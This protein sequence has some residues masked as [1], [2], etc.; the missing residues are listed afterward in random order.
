MTLTGTPLLVTLI[1]LAVLMPGIVIAAWPRLRGAAWLVLTQRVGLVLVAQLSTLLLAGVALNDYG[2]FFSSWSQAAGAFFANTPHNSLGNQPLGDLNSYG[3]PPNIVATNSTVLKVAP[4]DALP[5]GLKPTNW[6]P[7]SQYATRGAVATWTLDGPTSQL[8]NTVA[9]YLPPAYFQGYRS[10]PL[11]EAITGYPATYHAWIDKLTLPTQ[12]LDG[13]RARLMGQLVVVMTPAGVP[14]PL[15]SECTDAPGGPFAYTYFAKD[16]PQETARALG[17]RVT[18]MGALGFSTGGYCAIKLAMLDPSSFRAAAGMSGYFAAEP[19]RFS[20]PIFGGSAQVRHLNDL[21]WR[22]RH[23]PAPRTSVLV[24]TGTE[25]I[26][27]DGWVTNNK[28]LDAV[29]PP[30]HADRFIV[31]VD[32][33][34]S[35]RTWVQEVSPAL[36]WISRMLGAV[37]S[38]GSIGSALFSRQGLHRH[39]AH[40][41]R[42]GPTMA[43]SASPSA[44]GTRSSPASSPS[45]SAAATP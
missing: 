6:S 11:V 27:A 44:M 12:L 20:P 36:I 5:S 40:R 39:H 7:P 43:P 25:E 30:M 17:L 42:S 14:Y 26:D 35:P 45:R 16:V 23:L 10:L 38:Q 2:D 41:P 9:V 24:M 37:H 4:S 29:R 22:L 1:V 32:F 19:G 3:A 15:D 13:I 33:G 8:A 18:A 21:L 31:P 34:H 28:F